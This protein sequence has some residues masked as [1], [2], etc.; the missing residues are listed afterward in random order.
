M[1]TFTEKV[2]T[3]TRKI[4][5]G[6][7]ITYGQIAQMVGNPKASRAVGMCMSR[8]PDNKDV[9]CHRVVASDGR[10]T[11]FAFGGITEKH[12][13]LLKEGIKII[14]NKV[15]LVNFQWHP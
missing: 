14:G 15:D 7:V 12:K 10:L 3:L 9:P 1:Q 2:Y 5:F 13:K 4:P 8:N 6:K 11:G